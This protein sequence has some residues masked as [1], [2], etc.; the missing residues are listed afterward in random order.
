MGA[1][2]AIVVVVLLVGSGGGFYGYRQHGRTWPGRSGSVGRNHPSGDLV[3][4]RLSC[5]IAGA[6]ARSSCCSRSPTGDAAVPR[7]HLAV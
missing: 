1:T 6:I 3:R 2:L 4:R 5:G 7:R